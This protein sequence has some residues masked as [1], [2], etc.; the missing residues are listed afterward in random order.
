[1]KMTA[2]RVCGLVLIGVAAVACGNNRKSFKPN[3]FANNVS[4]NIPGSTT[5][6]P[7]LEDFEGPSLFSFT[8]G[9]VLWEIGTP[10][11]GP[12]T[13]ANGSSRAAGTDL[14]ADYA[15]EARNEALVSPLISFLNC[16][17]T[18]ASSVCTFSTM[19]WANCPLNVQ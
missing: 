3:P 14:D 13:G 9:R 15:A 16:L 19:E 2:L 10:T 7:V 8:P 12:G 5:T 4:T 17:S 11:Q 18:T 1:M 6:F